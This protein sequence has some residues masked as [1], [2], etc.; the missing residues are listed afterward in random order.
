MNKPIISS[1]EIESYVGSLNSYIDG[2]LCDMSYEM[3][4][5]YCNDDDEEIIKNRVISDFLSFCRTHCVDAFLK[6][7]QTP[8]ILDDK[9][10]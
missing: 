8:L 7:I 9:Q 5:S 10:K 6:H 3:E 1:I 2:L 4:D